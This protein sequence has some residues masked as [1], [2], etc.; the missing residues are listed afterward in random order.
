L[1]PVRDIGADEFNPG[2]PVAHCRA[3]AGRGWSRTP[4]A[5]RAAALKKCK[6]KHGRARKRCKKAG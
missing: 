2:F 6:R 3:A 4:R 5:S 1:T